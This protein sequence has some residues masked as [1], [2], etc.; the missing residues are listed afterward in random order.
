M[1][2]HKQK[3]AQRKYLQLKQQ[4]HVQTVPWSFYNESIHT[5]E[6]LLIEQEKERKIKKGKERRKCKSNDI[7]DPILY[8]RKVDLRNIKICF[9]KKGGDAAF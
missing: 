4:Y 5:F 1:N 8:E 9:T 6:L 3:Q 7:Y 2:M